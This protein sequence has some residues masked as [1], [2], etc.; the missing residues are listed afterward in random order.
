[1][2][3]VDINKG[4]LLGAH[5][6]TT[7][8]I[9]KAPER[10]GELHCSAIQLFTK[11]SNQWKA[12]PLTLKEIDAFKDAMVRNGIKAAFAHS[13]YLINLSTV[14]PAAHESSMESMRLEIERVEALEL[15]YLIVHPG[16][17]KEAGEIVGI[18]QLVENLRRLRDEFKSSHVQIVL[19]TT[20]GQGTNIGY[21]FEHFA[22]IFDRLDWPP[23]IG[24]CMDTA[25][26]FQAG[27]DISTKDGYNDVM[28]AF[29]DIVGI[30]YIRV[31]HLND[32]KTGCGS[33]VDRHESIGKGRI[34]AEAFKLFIRDRRFE[35]VPM[36]IETP[37]GTTLEEDAANLKLLRSF[38]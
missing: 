13:G 27:Y 14:D 16:S 26:M 21:S 28:Q 9:E 15:P 24:V 3:A 5:C 20:A 7:G 33:R 12:P 37:K 4:R 31:I 19:E 23:D 35:K 25:H 36:V 8:G 32:S 10:G 29:N 2:S 1:M 6:S 22:E 38:I 30:D 18:I 17:H 34:G 11:N